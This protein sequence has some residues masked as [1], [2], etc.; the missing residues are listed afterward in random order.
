MCVCVCRNSIQINIIKFKF[1]NYQIKLV[2]IVTKGIHP[3]TQRNRFDKVEDKKED[4]SYKVK[5]YF[6][7]DMMSSKLGKVIS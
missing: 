1:R 3:H 2:E 5:S 6:G 4:V 7:G